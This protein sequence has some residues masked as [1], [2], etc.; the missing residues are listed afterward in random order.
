MAAPRKNM[1][2][3]SYL[4]KDYKDLR[5][6]LLKYA[7]T[8]FPDKIQDFSES[9]VGGMMLDLAAA[10]G[11][12]MSFYLDHQFR[13]TLWT[14]AVE[15]PNIERMIK[16]NGIK[17]IGA[18]PSVVKLSFYVRV[19]SDYDGLAPDRSSLP[20][21]L[22]GTLV[23]SNENVPFTTVED[24]DFS[25]EDANGNLTAQIIITDNAVD[26]NTGKISYFILKKDVDAVSGRVYVETF[27]FGSDFIPYSTIVLT[28][29]N[30]SEILSVTDTSGDQWYEV[31]SLTQDTAYVGIVNMSDDKKLVSRNMKV[32]PAS[33]R[34][35]T[36]VDLQSRTTKLMFGGGDP[37]LYDDDIFP[38]PSNI[39][40][41]LYGKKEITRF[42]LDPNALLKSRTMGVAPTSTTITVTYRAGGGPSHNVGANFIRNIKTLRMSFK[43]GAKASNTA[44]IRA[45][46]DVINEAPAIGG[47]IAPTIDELRS[48]IPASRNMQSRIVTKTDLLS[49][50]YSLPMK[51]GNVYKAGV[52]QDQNNPMS[53]QLFVLSRDNLGKLIISPDSLKQ[54]LKIYLNEYRLISDA[55]DVLDG[56]IINFSVAAKIIPAPN[57]NPADVIKAVISAIQGNF[58]TKKTQI[59]QPIVTSEIVSSIINV[60]GVL[61]LIDLTFNGISGYYDGKQYSNFSFD[62]N[63]NNIRGLIIGPPGSIFE[64]RYPNTDVIVSTI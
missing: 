40:I 6:D 59:D 54:N 57:T 12:N 4:S 25:E 28:N 1:V 35:I 31:E 60:P 30:V 64:L 44:A 2:T 38:D 39:T 37:E 29:P 18:S 43:S 58:D 49:R 8:F 21:I 27:T 48:L 41:P 9:S 20:V 5:S 17:V 3:R 14:D 50:V 34:F 11:D 36:S 32:V 63:L 52:M 56:S 61:S 46:V 13:E 26:K 55:I 22:E 15:V 42:S 10:V 7:R 24:L 33:K 23:T 47:K 53:T 62:M 19:P 51:F 16:N 45:S